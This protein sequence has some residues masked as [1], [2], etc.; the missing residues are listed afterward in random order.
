MDGRL[1]TRSLRLP[2]AFLEHN[3]PQAMIAAAGLDSTAIA[4]TAL[5]ALEVESA[6]S[7]MGPTRRSPR[8]VM[9]QEAP[10]GRSARIGT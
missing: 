5:A 9:M 1:R 3:S 2:D 8:A 4:R 6:G 10:N 7:G